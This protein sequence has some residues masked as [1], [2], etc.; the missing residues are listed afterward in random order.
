[1]MAERSARER[2]VVNCR[3]G[4]LEGARGGAG[5]SRTFVAMF[6]SCLTCDMVGPQ[7]RDDLTVGP[8]PG[9]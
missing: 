8:L 9:A 1:M 2:F 5:S 4:L 3:G 6:H 7:T